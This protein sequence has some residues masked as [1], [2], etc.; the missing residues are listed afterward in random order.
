MY[1]RGFDFEDFNKGEDRKIECNTYTVT[2]VLQIECN[3]YTV[4]LYCN[5]QVWL[6]VYIE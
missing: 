6:L 3:T 4:K 1:S 2:V 5:G